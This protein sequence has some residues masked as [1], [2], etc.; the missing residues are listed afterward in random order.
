[1]HPW[2]YSPFKG[3]KDGLRRYKAHC[4]FIQSNTRISIEKTFGMFK[5]RF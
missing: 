3:E 4:N 2:F 1:M 5:G